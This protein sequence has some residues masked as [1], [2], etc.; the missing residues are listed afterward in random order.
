MRRRLLAVLAVLA[1]LTTML[2]AAPA[3]GQSEGYSLD[4]LKQ[5]GTHYAVDGQRLVPSENRMYWLEFEPPNQPWQSVTKADNGPKFGSGQT[6]QT[7]T[8]H[9][10][11][12]LASTGTETRTVK[13]VSWQKGSKTVR[14]GNTTTSQ[15]VAVNVSTTTQQVNFEPIQ[16][17]AEVDLP[18][19]DEPHQITMW[20]E[21]A[22]DEARWRFTH[23]SV[24]TTQPINVDDYSDFVMLAG[25]FVILPAVAMQGYGSRKVRDAIDRAAKGPG[26]GF[27]YYA[28]S[29]TVLTGGLLAFAYTQ[30]AEIIVAA[31]IV[32]GGY[33]ALVST[34]YTLATHEGQAEEKLFWQPH[35]ESVESFSTA[36]FPSVGS[37]DADDSLDFSEDMP[38]GTM[39]AYN[40]VDEGQRGLSVIR[41]GWLPFL[42]RIKGGRAKIE[43]AHELTTRFSLFDSEWDECFIVDPEADT[44]IDYKPPGLRLKTP[45]FDTW[46]EALWPV[47]IAVGVIG[48]TWW[49]AQQ[50]GAVAWATL[51]L[52]AAVYVWVYAVEGTDSYCRV[53]PAPAAMR[54]VL[55]SMLVMSVGN[56]D[57]HRL[58]DAEE[59][60]WKALAQQ[61]DVKADH[62][63]RGDQ[64]NVE[65]AFGS[66]AGDTADEDDVD[67]DSVESAD[68]DR[69]ESD[70]GGGDIRDLSDPREDDDE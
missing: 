7:N 19:H 64:S 21:G 45:E 28:I 12:M 39:Q 36:K 1:L 49:A 60:A 46:R 27:L 59:F 57:A 20:V 18:Q 15:P 8:I 23:E 24:A 40:V 13:I 51:L 22:S 66:A 41:D 5:D 6:L 52:A 69:L 26:H 58:Q 2:A 9:L 43:N 16:G 61:E 35:I 70:T 29:I 50:Y 67:S 62:L 47:G 44:L 33:V 48:G 25:A 30:L 63:R 55:A 38:F 17:V 32:L 37:G 4:E 3:A 56:R 54:P 53:E 34:G 42:A 65:A 31:P 14:N 68:V 10:R 11:T